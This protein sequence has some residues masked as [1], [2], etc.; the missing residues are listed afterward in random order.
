VLVSTAPRVVRVLPDRAAIDK[1]FDYLVPEHLG[2]QVRVGTIVRIELHGRRVGGWVLEDGVEP[3]PG[4]VARPLA[5]VTG[6]GPAPDVIDLA[7]WATWRW[8]G[9]LATVLGSASPERAVPTLPAPA[10]RSA[11]TP[12]GP[13]D[14][15]SSA[16]DGSL[17]GCT[18]RLPP[19][20]DP[21]PV[22]LAA[23]ARGDSLIITPSVRAAQHL[24]VRLRRAGV[25]VAVLPRE[26]AQA[27]A[28]GVSVIGA[29]GA[30]W[31][32]VAHLAA[33]VVLDEHDEVHQEERTPTWS[34]RDVAIERAR[35]AGVP[36]VLVSA[37][38]S[39]EALEWSRLL[40]PSRTEEREGWPPVQIVDR[41]SD[42]AGR[43][44]LFSEA[45]VAAF[46]QVPS[47]RT[48]ICVLNR[49]G[50]S[51]LLACRSCGE[52]ARCE[53][54]DSAVVQSDEGLLACH[55]CGV[56]RPTVCLAC[57]STVLRNL[58]MGVTRAREELAS[59]LGEPVVEVT[60]AQ[61]GT[62]LADG[63][64]FVGTEAA[65]HQVAAAG[66][67]AF[68]DFDQELLAPRYRAAEEAL[69]LLVRAGRLVGGRR[70]GGR[71]LVQTR[72]PRHDVLVAA[73]HAEPGKLAATEGARRRE[74][75]WPP[76]SAMAEVSGAA[77]AAYVEGFGEPDGVQVRGPL[78]GRWLLRA[79][80]HRTL[81]D[82]LAATPRP[83]T[84]SG[85]LRIAVDPPRV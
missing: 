27:R 25:P 34:A 58:R 57:G 13:D 79:R 14:L 17:P 82:A 61:A 52:L 75:G 12:T 10:H 60:G 68:L 85:R 40:T 3:P 63:R 78:E 42:D 1:T 43:T 72:L 32:P 2:D 80:D 62:Q 6:W 20:A 84:S 67:V 39:L 30:A 70:G 45:F 36:C 77:A 4:V 73:L 41:R 11:P 48:V 69:A 49:T 38:P 65:L 76:F 46:R 33:V 50:R 24:G 47:D 53:A 37:C 64:V 7:R 19:S 21:Y 55:R 29:R 83:P 51:K 5:K 44:G 18:L 23:V 66:L 71:V 81:C 74:L 35:R 9:R 28:G 59:L 22:L 8:A 15:A 16:F 56:Q 54:C 26:W 31:A